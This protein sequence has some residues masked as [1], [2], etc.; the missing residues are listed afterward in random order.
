MVWS[1]GIMPPSGIVHV[2]SVAHPR[3][4]C[5]E[6]VE[7]SVARQLMP[8]ASTFAAMTSAMIMNG[9]FLKK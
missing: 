8:F 6:V 9:A 7:E 3:A 1:N 5:R 4:N 2:H